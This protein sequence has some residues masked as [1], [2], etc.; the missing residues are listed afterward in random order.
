DPEDRATIVRQLLEQGTVEAFECR[1]R[2]KDGQVIWILQNARAVFDDAGRPL[3]FEGTV[4]DITARK[5]VEDERVR[6][7]HE[8]DQFFSSISH[9]LR[10][11]LAAITASIGVVLANEPPKTP[12][13][14]H[15][16]LVNIEE[17][18]DDM[19]QLVEDLLVL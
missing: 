12:P 19:A 3:Y 17:S 6:L 14:L 11:P 10:T 4:E 18:A 2:R 16:L 15:R 9:D 13:A 7:E 1:V 8:R 5:R